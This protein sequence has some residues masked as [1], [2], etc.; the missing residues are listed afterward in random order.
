MLDS[1]TRWVGD[2]YG[3]D[4]TRLRRTTTLLD[5]TETYGRVVEDEVQSTTY[6]VEDTAA[7]SETALYRGKGGELWGL[8]SLSD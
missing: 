7:I 6:D 4:E 1:E 3:G 5:W 2:C 8:G